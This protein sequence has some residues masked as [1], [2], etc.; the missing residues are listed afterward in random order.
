M[1]QI[2][3]MFLE[4][5]QVS[6]GTRDGLSRVPTAREWEALY[7]EAE[8]QAIV[9]VLLDGIERL[10]VSGERLADCMP[11][12]EVKLQ[13]IGAVQM[14]EARNRDMDKISAQML[15]KFAA[16]GFRGCILKGQGNALMYPNPERRQSGDIDIWLS[17]MSVSGE[18]LAV[19]E[20]RTVSGL[21]RCRREIIRYVTG[22][23]PEMR[24]QLHHVDYPPV[25]DAEV[26]VHF[27]PIYLK[28]PFH[29]RRLLRFFAEHAEEQFANKV[30]TRGGEEL[31][32]P[33]PAFNAVYQMVHVYLHYL[34]Q[35]VG[36]RHVVDYYYVLR[37]VSGFKV[38]GSRFQ[39]RG[40]R[41]AVSGDILHQ[42]SSI[43]HQL[44]MDKFAAAMM[45][46]Q[47]EVCGA[48]REWLLCEPDEREGRRLLDEMMAMGNFGKYDE[49]Y[50]T[51][52]QKGLRF[53]VQK[54]RRMARMAVAYPLEILWDPYFRV[55]LMLAKRFRI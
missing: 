50:G 4:L 12:L 9:G 47:K 28:N 38:Q 33:T 3:R 43:F 32:V 16:D 7:D 37:Q 19:S 41:L 13:W 42:T 46:V 29:H 53:V 5:I 23:Y 30:T 48:P 22:R 24:V 36:M 55:R 8:R 26:E 40:E 39:V 31:T 44:G 52:E 2:E 21:L 15:R 45:W 10:A 17:P 6:L 20:E 49:R 18:R 27:Y 35:G 25:D 34:F 14:D 51:G 54:L 11:P 1:T